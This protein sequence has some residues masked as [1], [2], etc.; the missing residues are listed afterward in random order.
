MNVLSFSRGRTSAYMLAKYKDEIDLVVFA[1]TGKEALGT[2]DFVRKCGEYFEKDIVWLE[3]TIVN[4]Q[5]FII[6]NYENASRDGQPFRELIHKRRFIPNVGMRFCSMEMKALTIKR[7]LKSIGVDV[8]EVDMYLGIRAD[9]PSRYHR[10]KDN[11]RNGWYNKM[12]LYKDRIT[13]EDVLNYWSNQPFDLDI[14]R[15]EG[16][17]D[18]CFLKGM[19]KKLELLRQKPEVAKFWIEM[20]Q[21]IG[22]TFHKKYSV[23]DILYMSQSQLNL[24]D[25]FDDDIECSCNID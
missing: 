3:Y 16:N 12:P 11:M 18:L 21:T 9:E 8:K 6:V 22:K 5:K 7:Y 25:G 15:W 2:L 13:E 10:L 4:K 14:N 24:F 1:N 17:C 19:S 20:E 23:Q